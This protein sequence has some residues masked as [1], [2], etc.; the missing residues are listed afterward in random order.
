MRVVLNMQEDSE[1]MQRKG[2]VKEGKLAIESLSVKTHRFAY[3]RGPHCG[4]LSIVC[5]QV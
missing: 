5:K 3:R 1:E 2:Q 4:E